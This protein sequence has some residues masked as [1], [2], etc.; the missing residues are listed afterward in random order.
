M[1]YK[2]LSS[3]LNNKTRAAYTNNNIHTQTSYNKAQNSKLSTH[4][5]HLGLLTNC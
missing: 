3:T 2:A 1:P 4:T 5:W